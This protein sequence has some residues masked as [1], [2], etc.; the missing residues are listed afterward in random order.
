MDEMMSFSR[1]LCPAE[2][3]D[4]AAETIRHVYPRYYP[5]G[6]VEY[7]LGLHSVGQIAASM[8][9]EDIYMLVA[10]G[11]KI[12]TGSV[13]KNEIC[14]LFIKPEFQGQGYGTRLMDELE[15]KIYRQYD[16]VHVDASFPAER[17]YLERGYRIISYD[18]IKTDNG[19]YLCYHTME[20]RRVV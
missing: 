3:A 19:D 8:H 6:A 14:R 11:I 13:R 15:K 17:M 7:F 5:E 2:A 12:G 16:T 9:E 4:I 20:K 10:D 1:T 18:K